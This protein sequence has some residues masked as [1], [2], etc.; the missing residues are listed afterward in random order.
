MMAHEAIRDA[1]VRF[2]DDDAGLKADTYELDTPLFSSGLLDSFA[3]V[4]VLAF[5][6]RQ[7]GVALAPENMTQANI[8]TVDGLARYIEGATLTAGID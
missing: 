2:L 4:A 1:L 8:D 7:F 6:E 3:L 5:A